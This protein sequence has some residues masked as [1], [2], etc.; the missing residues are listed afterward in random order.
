MALKQQRQAVSSPASSDSEGL[1]VGAG[2]PIEA[3]Q[4]LDTA[5]ID[6]GVVEPQQEP[7][8]ADRM[9]Q[10]QSGMANAK[11]T[12]VNRN[13]QDEW[14]TDISL[15]YDPQRYGARVVLINSE[16]GSVPEGPRAVIRAGTAVA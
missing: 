8:E 13:V 4:Q 15:R 10:Q 11:S 6:S 3:E 14:R 9:T 2:F 16:R 7:P 5:T 1:L 12:A